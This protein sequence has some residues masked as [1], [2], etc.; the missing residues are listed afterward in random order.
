MLFTNI[1]QLPASLVDVNTLRQGEAMWAGYV[2][3]CN[4]VRGCGAPA[5]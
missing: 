1:A 3:L 2:R 4:L 5:E